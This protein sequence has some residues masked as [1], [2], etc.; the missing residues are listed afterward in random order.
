V[1]AAFSDDLN[2]ARVASTMSELE[3]ADCVEPGAKFEA[4]TYVDRMLAVDLGRVLG[5][6]GLTERIPR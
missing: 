1:V 4:F 3:D 2:V 5:S 6:A